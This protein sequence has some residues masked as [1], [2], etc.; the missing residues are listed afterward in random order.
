MI[1]DIQGVGNVLTDPQIHCLDKHR[2]GKGN[3]GYLGMLMFFNTHECNE[4]CQ[5]LGLINPRKTGKV[6]NADFKLIKDI[7]Y[8]ADPTQQVHKLCDLCKKPFYTT[9]GHYREKRSE[10]HEVWC[11]QCTLKR[12]QSVTKSTC[13]TCYKHFNYSGYWFKMKKSDPPVDCWACRLRKREKE[14]VKL[15]GGLKKS[16]KHG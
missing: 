5:N 16:L 10:G 7:D 12:D 6:S 9:L 2:F 14:R 15:S 3:L 13:A 8:E 1:V 11:Q 4:H